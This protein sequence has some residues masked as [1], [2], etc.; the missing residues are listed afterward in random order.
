MQ[1]QQDIDGSNKDMCEYTF[2]LIFTITNHKKLDL[3]LMYLRD[4]KQLGNLD[5]VVFRKTVKAKHIYLGPPKNPPDY[6]IIEVQ[7]HKES[8]MVPKIHFGV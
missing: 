2:L 3:I 7:T 1:G 5:T 4:I 8:V 6:H